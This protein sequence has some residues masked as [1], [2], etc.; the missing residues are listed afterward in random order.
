MVMEK[1][2]RQLTATFLTSAP[3]AK[4]ASELTFAGTLWQRQGTSEEGS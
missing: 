3:A 4:T 2:G 1:Q